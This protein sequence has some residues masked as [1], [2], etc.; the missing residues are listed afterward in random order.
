MYIKIIVEKEKRGVP[1]GAFWRLE[2]VKKYRFKVVF[3]RRGLDKFDISISKIADFSNLQLK[4]VFSATYP[5]GTL[6]R[7]K[8]NLL[9]VPT[10]YD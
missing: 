7:L 3:F 2:S 10:L 1:F 4:T 6:S 8:K 9:N 5:P